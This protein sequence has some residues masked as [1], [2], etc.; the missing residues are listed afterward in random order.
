[1]SDEAILNEIMYGTNGR[2]QS[3]GSYV[4]AAANTTDMGNGERFAHDH[5]GKVRYCEDFGGFLIFDGK[6]WLQD[7]TRE[8]EA[9][10][11]S[12]VRGIYGEAEQ[13]ADEAERKRVAKWA[14]QSESKARI[15]AM[16][17]CAR[18]EPGIPLT[19]E[20][21]DSD[22]RLL[23]AENGTVSLETGGITPHDADD[24]ITKLAPVEYA[25]DAE[26]PTW[27]AFLERVLP[28]AALRRFVQRA[29][30]HSLLGETRE[31]VLFFLYGTGAN[32]KSTFVN[33]ILEALGDY[34]RQAPPELLTVKGHTHPTELANLK[35]ARF[36]A[37]VEVEEGKRLA[38]SLVKQLTGRDRISARF[39]RQD[40]FDFDPTHTV[41]LAANHKPVVRGTDLAIWRR[42]KL[43]PFTVTI[44]EKERDPGLQKKLRSE[45]AGVLAWAVRGCLDYLE[46]GLGEPDEVRDATEEYRAEMDVLAA[47]FAEKC[48]VHPAAWCAATP[49]YNA[50]KAWCEESGETP[51]TQRRFGARLTERGFENFKIT[52]G[53]WKDRKGWRGIGLLEDDPGPD[54]PDDGNDG[55]K[56]PPKGTEKGP[57]PEEEA[58]NRPLDANGVGIAKS[59]D[60]D[61]RSGQ[62]GPRYDIDGSKI[63]HEAAMSELGPLCPLSPLESSERDA[64]GADPLG[65]FLA[66]PPGWFVEEAN[67]CWYAGRLDER[68]V[69]PLA[70]STA[71]EVFG[72]VQRW[73]E[74]R[75]AVERW[76]KGGGA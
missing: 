38:E 1:M 62:S 61:R 47:F 63:T 75:P 13:S 57:L 36:V 17:F 34:A 24:L 16:L 18:S 52:A 11:K 73:R 49:L 29:V 21:L 37:S 3:G 14:M 76:L 4:G 23:N 12:T 20:A 35:G 30:G 15:D 7:R 59:P 27:E 48:V 58:D 56:D 55:G 42:I 45:L 19:P 33:T 8:A 74:A 67:R 70:S 50:Y 69:A 31:E 2:G 6:R 60:E 9:L 44:P 40:F 53:A 51:E 10:A 71:A 72:D 32:G 41:F 54:N 5:G 46:H 26:A 64:R 65:A 28:S 66:D 43:V 25:P 68:R 39:M 22:P